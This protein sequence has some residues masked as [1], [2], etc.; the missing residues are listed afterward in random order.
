VFGAGPA[1]F[2]E[3]I[4]E[5]FARAMQSDGQ[6]VAGESREG[7]QVFDQRFFETAHECHAMLIS[8][9]G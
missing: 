9:G 3:F 8:W 2:P 6:I 7:L 4:A 5:V 1:V